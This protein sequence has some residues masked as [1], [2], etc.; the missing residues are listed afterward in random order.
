MLQSTDSQNPWLY[1]TLDLQG[2]SI[3]FF[4]KPSNGHC[5]F[6]LM[7]FQYKLGISDVWWLKSLITAPNF[8][9]MLCLISLDSIWSALFD[10]MIF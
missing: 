1:L 7:N 10:L 2:A 3:Y 6:Y 9:K 5:L 8:T 4:C